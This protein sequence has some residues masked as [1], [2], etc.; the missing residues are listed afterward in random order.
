MQ[1]TLTPALTTAPDA[2]TTLEAVL[3]AAQQ[4]RPV[5][6]MRLISQLAA[7]VED[8]LVSS[9]PAPR[10]S[11]LGALAHLGPAPSAEEIDEARREA[12]GNSPKEDI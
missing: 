11:L 12:W 2:E 1:Q 5:D 7:S 9:A 10:R 3:T 6:K 8:T 4:L